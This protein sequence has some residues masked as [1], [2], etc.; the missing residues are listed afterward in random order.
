MFNVD[1]SDMQADDVEFSA[2]KVTGTL[3]YLSGSNAITDRW[4]EG[5]F[6]CFNMADEE[7]DYSKLTSVK[8]GLVPSVSSGL[9]D[10]IDDPDKNGVFKVTDKN[11]QI[12]KIVQT[13]GTHTKTQAWNLKDLVLEEEGEG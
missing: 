2:G 10:I 4:G 9:V 8:V 7:N 5:Y 3:K 13:D 1:V 12:F 11:I 6:L